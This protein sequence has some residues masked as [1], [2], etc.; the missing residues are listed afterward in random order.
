MEQLLRLLPVILAAAQRI[1]EL[2]QILPLLTQLGTTTFP[3]LSPD[4][5]PAAAATT[6]DVNG[7]KWTQTALNLLLNESLKIDGV[8][9]AA[10]KAA[11]SKFQTA[12]NLQADGWAGTK[13]ADALR[14]AL[15]A[16]H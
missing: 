8:Y 16:H 11:V 1:P 10:T 15:I 12:N 3:G 9:G 7:V 4:K 14:A 6:L 13:T 2:H 5:A